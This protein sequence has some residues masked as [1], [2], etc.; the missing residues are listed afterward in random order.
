MKIPLRVRAA[1]VDRS[2]A[3][4]QIEETA[5]DFGLSVAEVQSIVDAVPIDLREMFAA[6]EFAVGLDGRLH[7]FPSES[8]ID[9]DRLRKIAANAP[10]PLDF[11]L[12]GTIADFLDAENG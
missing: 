4:E 9:A 10:K 1:I 12:Y 8:M 5:D 2:L 11:P 7:Y 6:N 3:G